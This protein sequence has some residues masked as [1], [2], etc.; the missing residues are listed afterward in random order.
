MLTFKKG[1]LLKNGHEDSNK[2]Y[3]KVYL[4]ALFE[5]QVNNGCDVNVAECDLWM[6]ILSSL[7]RLFS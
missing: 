7:K 2:N 3:I 1:K 4:R 5:K 6:C